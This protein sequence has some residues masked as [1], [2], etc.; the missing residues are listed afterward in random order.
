MGQRESFIGA[1]C[2]YIGLYINVNTNSAIRIRQETPK[3]IYVAMDSFLFEVFNPNDAKYN[4][5]A[6][7]IKP[8]LYPKSESTNPQYLV[9]T[10]Q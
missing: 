2:A 1:F 3:I 7:T 9:Q 6:N 4:S 8:H 10:R 5:R